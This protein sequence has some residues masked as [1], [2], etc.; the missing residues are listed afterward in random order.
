MILEAP[1]DFSGFGRV[2]TEL[3]RRVQV[4]SALEASWPP[5]SFVGKG[6]PLDNFPIGTKNAVSPSIPAPPLN[7]NPGN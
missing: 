4:L 6:L 3:D 1:A 2:W 5:C 7:T